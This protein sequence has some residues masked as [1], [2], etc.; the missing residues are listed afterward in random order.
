M[1]GNQAPTFTSVPSASKP[2]QDIKTGTD[3]EYT[4]TATDEDGD[5][6]TTS[7]LLL[8]QIG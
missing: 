3:Y 5:R 2:S 4:L 1:T 8:T 7:Y 6:I